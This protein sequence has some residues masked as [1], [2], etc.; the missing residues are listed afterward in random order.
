VQGEKA[1]VDLAGWDVL[2]GLQL[3]QH[4]VFRER[5]EGV[6]QQWQVGGGM[7]SRHEHRTGRA[8]R[9]RALRDVLSDELVRLQHG[10]EQC[11]HDA[12]DARVG[13]VRRAGRRCPGVASHM[14]AHDSVVGKQLQSV[15]IEPVHPLALQALQQG[16]GRSSGQGGV[17]RQHTAAT[18]LDGLLQPRLVEA[19]DPLLDPAVRRSALQPSAIQYNVDSRLRKGVGQERA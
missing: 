9:W 1:S 17:A 19:L 8:E 13:D 10:L 12:A 16:R 4:A 14:V 11:T 7:V 6:L 3:A 5:P 2:A 15:C 18:T